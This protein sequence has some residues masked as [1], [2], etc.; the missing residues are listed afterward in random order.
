MRVL[1]VLGMGRSFK[2]C[3]ELAGGC[4]RGLHISE[5]GELI[6]FGGFEGDYI[7]CIHM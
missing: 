4:V 7:P 1:V 3:F 5:V 2:S 6:K